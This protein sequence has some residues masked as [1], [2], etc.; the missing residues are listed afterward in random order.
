MISNVFALKDK[1]KAIS[2]LEEGRK[3]DTLKEI[4]KERRI[5]AKKERVSRKRRQKQ[6]KKKT[7]NKKHAASNQASWISETRLPYNC[8]HWS[9]RVMGKERSRTL[10]ASTSKK[11]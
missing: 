5:K 1:F 2:L 7:K 11:E 10:S 8:Y 3:A 9:S 6:K 4:Q